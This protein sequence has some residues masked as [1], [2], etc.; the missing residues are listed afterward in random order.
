VLNDSHSRERDVSVRRRHLTAVV[1]AVTASDLCS[2]GCKHAETGF[3]R[4]LAALDNLLCSKARQ[5][6]VLEV[7][8]STLSHRATQVREI[9]GRR[10]SWVPPLHKC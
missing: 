5:L 10:S 4:R 3:P 7:E 1:M 9:E 2:V 6:P 8:F